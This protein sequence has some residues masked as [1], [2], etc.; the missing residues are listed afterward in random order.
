MALVKKGPDKVRR[1]AS[2]AVRRRRDWRVRGKIAVKRLYFSTRPYAVRFRWALLFFDLATIGFF[3]VTSFMAEHAWIYQIDAVIGAVLLLDFL[4][5]V[6]LVRAK[7]LFLVK[8]VALAD[9]IVIVSLFGA[10]VSENLAFLRVLRALRLLRSYHVLGELTRTFPWVRRN[11]ETIVSA[12]NLVVFIF[13]VTA[14]VYVSQHG[15]NPAIQNYMD[16]LY[17]T[18]ATLTTTGFGDVTLQGDW[19]HLLAILI[20]VL[21]ISLFIRLAQTIF[22]PSKVKYTCPNCG[23]SRHDPDAVHCKHCGETVNIP[24]EGVV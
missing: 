11:E 22:R 17:F 16:A 20:M 19:G 10:A 8:P 3:V 13:V 15:T 9:M 1:D 21:G 5:R 7:W 6:W 18:I 24:T 4:A 14:F 23:L 2:W 12:L